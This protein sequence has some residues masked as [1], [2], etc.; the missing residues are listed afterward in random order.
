MII[1]EKKKPQPNHLSFLR[2]PKFQLKLIYYMWKTEPNCH[3]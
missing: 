1:L 3:S 2:K